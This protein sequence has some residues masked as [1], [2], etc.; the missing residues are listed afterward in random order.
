M[1]NSPCASAGAPEMHLSPAPRA[2]RL[3]RSAAGS[4][5]LF[6][7]GALAQQAAADALTLPLALPGASQDLGRDHRW[8]TAAPA[9]RDGPYARAAAQQPDPGLEV[10]RRERSLQWRNATIIGAG[11]V[12]I[13]AYGLSQWWHEGFGGGFKTV[14]E[15][16]LSRGTTYGGADKLGHA[17]SNYA[18]VRVL[19]PLFKSVGNDPDGSIRLAAWTTLGVFTGVEVLDGYSRRY[20]FS[21]QD[22]V[23]NAA[24]AALGVLL[25]TH[26]ALDE[27]FD[28][29]FGYKPSAGSGFSPFGDY[30]GQRYLLVAKADGFDSLR[31]VPALR[32]LEVG[33][34]YQARGFDPGGERRR[35]VM[36]V[37]SLNLSRL[38]ADGFYGG[39]MHSTRSQRTAER[40]FELVQFPT[41]ASVRKS[42]D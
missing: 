31:Q 21:P 19:S 33:V 38:L 29:R 24:G 20:R 15:G 22:A 26:P 10:A 32:Y 40:V 37:A 8:D 42:L 11:T 16:W 25:E 23:M 28:I 6:A 12:A 36:V 7:G 34:G 1:S 27:R 13:G 9:G 2:Q 18:S 30:S 5:C 14:N 39:Q 17:Y 41:D 4:A 35:E 3:W